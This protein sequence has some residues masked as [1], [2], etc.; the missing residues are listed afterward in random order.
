MSAGER[1]GPVV[2]VTQVGA[3]GG[4]SAAAAA[5]ACA[6]SES[7][8]AA[9]L[10]DVGEGRAP[11]ATL[12]ATTGARAMEER[13]A[14]HLPD[15]AIASRGR[16]CEL[17]ISPGPEAL[18]TLAAALPLSRETAAVVHLTPSL[19]RAAIAEPHIRPT[20]ALLRADLVEDRAL[21]ALVGRDLIARGL[22]VA[23]LKRPLDWLTAR[24]AG[25]GA[26]PPGA[27]GLSPRLRERLL[28]VEDKKLQ[29]CYDEGDGDEPEET[30]VGW[31]RP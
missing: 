14:A 9:L 22:R 1:K 26:L 8:R 31:G 12:V 13:L 16:I 30:Q 19:L 25:L 27:G 28:D 4:S 18:A 6:A 21:T 20:A 15:A 23:V 3:A 24:A 2:L 11:R 17:R 7:D 10:V 5:L 29:Q